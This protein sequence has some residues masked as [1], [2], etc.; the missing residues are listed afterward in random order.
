MAGTE[1]KVKIDEEYRGRAAKQSERYVD[2]TIDVVDARVWWHIGLGYSLKYLI[3][4]DSACIFEI[5]ENLNH[6]SHDQVDVTL[7]SAVRNE[8][9]H[10]I[11]D[12]RADEG[13]EEEEAQKL[14]KEFQTRE[15]AAD[16]QT[17]QSVSE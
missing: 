4:V 15:H 11:S 14:E 17:V 9:T 13:A 6:S 12:A 1:V 8:E 5:D 2:V 10:D 16:S 3:D 7:R